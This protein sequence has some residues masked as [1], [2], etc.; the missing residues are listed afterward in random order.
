[1]GCT[2]LR[3]EKVFTAGVNGRGVT[4]RQVHLRSFPQK[5]LLENQKLRHSRHFPLDSI[6]HPAIGEEEWQDIQI[7][8]PSVGTVINSKGGSVEEIGS[9]LTI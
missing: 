5:T 1:M 7:L 4:A 8:D 2:F 3:W 9:K 6:P